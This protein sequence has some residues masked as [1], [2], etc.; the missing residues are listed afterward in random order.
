MA[1]SAGV[2]A[3]QKY[4][5]R[6]FTS[7]RFTGT[8]APSH[9][10]ITEL[11]TAL[12]G[13]LRR[14]R[15]GREFRLTVGPL[16]PTHSCREESLPFAAPEVSAEV[17]YSRCVTEAA[18]GDRAAFEHL[19]RRFA[20]MVHGVLLARVPLQETHDLLQEVFVAAFQGLPELRD[21]KAFGPWVA[22]IAR[23]KAADYHRGAS[24]VLE[25]PAD[26]QAPD[27]SRHTE[28]REVMAAVRSLPE[29]Y[30]ETLVLR[31]VE[32]LTGPE[33]AART[34]LAPD[35]VRVNLHRGVKLLKKRLGIRSER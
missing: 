29:T 10:R 15:T 31:F 6:L 12:P 8:E 23:N 17:D 19:Y 20:P 32:G 1:F 35:S 11:R 28:V 25:L 3:L 24:A 21:P 5:E 13:A 30:R 16:P 33:I 27:A 4:Y 34:G 9:R 7:L 2:H 14:A 22:A 26:L 18:T